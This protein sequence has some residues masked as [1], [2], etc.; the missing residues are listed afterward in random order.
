MGPA[1]F[2][3]V[4]LA[5]PVD[6]TSALLMIWLQSNMIAVV[7]QTM[8]IT[9]C[10]AAGEEITT[11]NLVGVVPVKWSGPS[12]DIMSNRSPPRRSR[13]PTRRSSAS[14]RSRRHAAGALSVSVR[15]ASEGASHG[16][17]CGRAAAGAAA[18]VAGAL[19]L[20]KPTKAELVCKDDN[21]PDGEPF[22]E[23]M[24][25]PTEY[26]LTR[27]SRSTRNR[28]TGHGRRH[29]AVQRHRTR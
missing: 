15:D 19:G 20:I 5:R 29:A 4:R 2:T 12:L 16:D 22:V 11:W 18:T 27:T 21:L 10:T 25:N 3:N 6:S 1:K 24:F 23:C 17:G 8:A 14:A 26:R 13:S 28:S 9:A 7:P